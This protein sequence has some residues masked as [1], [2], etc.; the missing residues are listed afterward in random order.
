MKKVQFANN[1]Y[2]HIF[3]RGV[4]KREVFL[5]H[6]D[7]SRFFQSMAE[8]NTLNPIGSIFENSFRKKTRLG[9]PVSK[10][11]MS[12]WNEYIGNNQNNFCEKNIIL[13]QFNNPE[14][15]KEFAESSLVNIKERKEL[16]K[17]LL[18]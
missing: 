17:L 13:N 12:A 16:E 11:S 3:N 1:E 7:L 8:F 14:E 4:D 2:Y 15:Y 5:D 18:E 6:D 10:L 9:N